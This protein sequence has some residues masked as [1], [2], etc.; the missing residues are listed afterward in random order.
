MWPSDLARWADATNSGP[1]SAKSRGRFGPHSIK[2]GP[3]LGPGGKHL[4]QVR[5]HMARILPSVQRVR[6]HMDKVDQHNGGGLDQNW[7]K[8]QSWASS[9]KLGLSWSDLRVRPN[10]SR[11]VPRGRGDQDWAV[12]GQGGGGA[13]PNFAAIEEVLGGYDQ[14]WSELD[15]A[16]AGSTIIGSHLILGWGSTRSDPKSPHLDMRARRFGILIARLASVASHASLD[17]RG[18]CGGLSRVAPSAT[19]FS[20]EGKTTDFLGAPSSPASSDPERSRERRRGGRRAPIAPPAPFSGISGP[21][22]GNGRVAHQRERASTL[23]VGADVS[24][25]E[26]KFELARPKLGRAPPHWARVGPKLG[27]SRPSIGQA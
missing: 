1:D 20:S 7:A 14:P 19:K 9:A 26:S 10:T 21:N 12:F 2:C 8:I 15:R 22:R 25:E 18:P 17:S 5:P 4:W 16:W 24:W 27:R 3:T 11:N 6:H 13:D 23:G